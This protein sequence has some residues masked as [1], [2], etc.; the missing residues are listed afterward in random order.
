VAALR[1]M[2]RVLKPGGPLLFPEHGA[3]PDDSVRIWQNRIDPVW[4][5]LAGGCHSGR[6]IP[7]LLEQGGWKIDDM[8]EGYITGPKPLACNY[9]GSALAA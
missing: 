4:K 5:K 8:A 2:R 6:P 9:W 3:A 1:E 7:K